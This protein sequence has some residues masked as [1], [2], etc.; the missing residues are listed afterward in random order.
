MTTVTAPTMPVPAYHLP[1]DGFEVARN[2]KRWVL[3][4]VPG[5]TARFEVVGKAPTIVPD[6]LFGSALS[7][8]GTDT[9]VDLG[10][11]GDLIPG[12]ANTQE[13]LTVSLWVKLADTDQKDRALVSVAG[14]WS[15]ELDDSRKPRFLA[16]G[17][18]HGAGRAAL[19]SAAENVARL[20]QEVQAKRADAAAKRITAAAAMSANAQLR[21]ER[22]SVR[23]QINNAPPFLRGHLRTSLAVL[24][25]NEAS[26]ARAASDATT[27]AEQAEAEA[28]RAEEALAAAVQLAGLSATATGVGLKPRQWTHLV[29]VFDGSA[30][31]LYVNGAEAVKVEAGAAAAAIR[32]QA[33]SRLLIGARADGGGRLAGQLARFQQF[34]RALTPA[35]IQ[36]VRDT[37]Q[38]SRAAFRGRY[39]FEFELLDDEAQDVLYISDTGVNTVDVTITNASPGPVTFKRLDAGTS[40]SADHHHLELRFRPGTFRPRKA[41]TLPVAV[42]TGP[43]S[44]WEASNGPVPALDGVS[45]SLFLAFTGTRDK[46]LAAGESL[47]VTLEYQSADGQLGSRGTNVVLGY[48]NVTAESPDHLELDVGGERIRSV[49]IIS[50]TGRQVLPLHVGFYGSN[51]V[52]NSAAAGTEASAS[53]G[54]L[55]VRMRNTRPVDPDLPDKGL[56][57]FRSINSPDVTS[58]DRATKFTVSF[59][60]TGDWALTDSDKSKAVVLEWRVNRNG[61]NSTYQEGKRSDQGSSAIWTFNPDF[62]SLRPGEYIE[63]KLS[64]LVT[65]AATGRANIYVHYEDVPGYWDGQFALAVEKSPLVFSGGRVGV[66]RYPA[67]DGEGN[68]SVD[69]AVANRI[70]SDSPAGGLWI[71]RHGFFGGID[72][73]RLGIYNGSHWRL[74]V[75]NAGNVGIGTIE[76]EARLH[77]RG[78]TDADQTGGGTLVIGPTNSTN[79]AIDNNELIARNNGQASTLYLNSGGGR[80]WVGEGGLEIKARMRIDHG[81]IQR[82]GSDITATSD[83]GLYSRV[84][85]SWMRFVTNGGP[86]KFYTEHGNGGAG[87]TPRLTIESNGDVH[88]QR[89]ITMDGRL[90]LGDRIS[91]K[92]GSRRW[93][94]EILE[95]A[96]AFTYNGSHRVYFG[97]SGGGRLLSGS[98]QNASDMRLK[99]DIEDVLDPLA[100]ITGLRP[101][102]FR[103]LD[104][105]G[106]DIGFVAQEVEAVS[107][108]L[109]DNELE[110][111]GIAYHQFITLAVGAIQQQQVQIEELQAKLASHDGMG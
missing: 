94:T 41:R 40:P 66:A 68:S 85:G 39:P 96:L 104:H 83:L 27:A 59:D 32:H 53:A 109:V 71:Q 95:G 88:I 108:E 99:T 77:I 9:A 5:S 8:D 101:R 75:D 61:N 93:D 62:D 3:D 34:D 107:P 21:A 29:A 111:K 50:R 20:E 11:I 48:R 97:E 33:N 26:S 1:L 19:A 106:A 89:G 35:E 110:M 24:N 2:G 64:G 81:V 76:P 82:G 73:T 91:M 37:D 58:A 55:L 60:V 4:A 45:S 36:L 13:A 18:G 47:T 25:D 10:R 42:K 87:S 90:S 100:I 46:V 28:R 56:L 78:G 102:R 43:S 63:L 92:W 98:W 84:S 17:A 86:I 31:T 30:V 79:L 57:A 51:R 74:A 52:L 6:D 70:R 54:T 22:G 23:A 14:G 44:A 12:S 49:D 7:L 72:P 15:L 69:L 38:T 65:T 105:G 67:T 80:V 103:W 16:V